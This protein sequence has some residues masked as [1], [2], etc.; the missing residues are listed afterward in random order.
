M[1]FGRMVGALILGVMAFGVLAACGEDSTPTATPTD[2]PDAAITQEFD[3]VT[4]DLAFAPNEFQAEPGEA[5]RF[6]VDNPSNVVH[7]FSVAM[8]HELQ[9]VLT[10][11][12]VEEGASV[13]VDLVVPNDTVNLYLYCRIH[14]VQGMVG[15][16]G[17]G[18]APVVP[19]PEG[20][21][22]Y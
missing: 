11:V 17:V 15:A 12:E 8:T 16:I 7:T 2:V 3:V 21:F 10:D 22:G 4:T 19:T 13:E 20:G 9:E 18:T 14:A 5:V 6:N 1:L